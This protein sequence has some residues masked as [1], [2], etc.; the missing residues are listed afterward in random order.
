MLPGTRVTPRALDLPGLDVPR[1]MTSLAS[2][3]ETVA[4]APA[5]NAERLALLME[6]G[7]Y[8]GE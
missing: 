1:R 8:A 6:P 3:M 2:P 4:P 7:G 5:S